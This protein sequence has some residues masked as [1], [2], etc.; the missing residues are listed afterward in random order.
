MCDKS[1]PDS[2]CTTYAGVE[3]SECAPDASTLTVLYLKGPLAA[4]STSASTSASAYT[5]DSDSGIA[6]STLAP[7]YLLADEAARSAD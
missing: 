3:P 5:P 6:N 1:D 4:N 7:D 2:A